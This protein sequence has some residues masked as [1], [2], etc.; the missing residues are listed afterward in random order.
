MAFAR[1]FARISRLLFGIVFVVVFVIFLGLSY[2]TK[3]VDLGVDALKIFSV[4]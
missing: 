3:W 1:P 4:F 2:A